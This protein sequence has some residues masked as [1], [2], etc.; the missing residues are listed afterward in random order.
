MVAYAI[1]PALGK[2]KQV[3]HEF[4]AILNYIVSSGPAWDI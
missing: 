1:I 2:L 4:E 3:D